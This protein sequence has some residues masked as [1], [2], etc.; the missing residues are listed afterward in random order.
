MGQGR[1]GVLSVGRSAGLVLGQRGP[2]PSGLACRI[3]LSIRNIECWLLK[4]LHVLCMFLERW[5][6]PGQSGGS[7]VVL[8][9][10]ELACLVAR[11]LPCSHL[12]SFLR[13]NRRGE[14]C[15][16]VYMPLSH[17]M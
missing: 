4:P 8:D 10:H 16:P 15:V 5:E 9:M 12:F 1:M 11:Q 2:L 3:E 13:I 14:V 7:Q 17:P 6:S